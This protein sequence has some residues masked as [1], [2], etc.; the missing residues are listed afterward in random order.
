METALNYRENMSRSIALLLV[1]FLTATFTI[2]SSPVAAAPRTIFVPDDYPTISAAIAKAGEGDTIFVK[3][4]T[5]QEQTLEINKPLLLMG[6]DV[7]ET[8]VNLDP[9]LVERMIFHNKLWVP[10]T[11]VII[12]ADNVKLSGLTINMPRDEYGY[13]SGLSAN[14]DRIEIVGNRI[15]NRI[16]LSLNGKWMSFTDNALTGNLGVDGSNHTIARNSVDGSFECQGAFNKIIENKIIENPIY[17]DVNFNCTFSLIM[18]N[19]FLTVFLHSNSSFLSNNTFRC[20]TMKCSDNIVCNNRVTGRNLH[21]TTGDDLWG[22]LLGEG[23]CNVFHDNL[24]TGYRYGIAVGGTHNVAERNTFYRN[25]LMSNLE[26][27]GTNWEVLGAGNSW[28]NGKEGNYW[29][30]YRGSDNNGD[31]IGD[32]PYPVGGRRWW[33]DGGAFGQD[34]YPLMAPFDITSVSIELP[35]WANALLNASTGPQTLEHFSIVPV[36]ALSV[37]TIA[38]TSAGLL[39]YF[40]KRKRQAFTG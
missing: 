11:A 19:S 4:G 22:I 27:V 35:D 30:D 29:D 15:G 21:S 8:T 5:Y 3:K 40:R 16:C 1:I 26:H 24:I 25:I 6:E 9:P 36:V 17:D 18:G 34:N 20:L 32:V 38:I 37:A 10:S 23:S 39:V 33:L 13:G 12:N 2:V 31:G 7:N 14:G 28:D